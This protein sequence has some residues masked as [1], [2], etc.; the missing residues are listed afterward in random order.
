VEAVGAIAQVMLLAQV[1]QA[2]VK[3]PVDGQTSA[4]TFK[5]TRARQT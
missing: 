1:T 2:A 5:Q 3:Q 4:H